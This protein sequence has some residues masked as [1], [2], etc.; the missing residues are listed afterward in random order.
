MVHTDTLNVGL[1]LYN[2]MCV[3]GGTLGLIHNSVRGNRD[4]HRVR[5]LLVLGKGGGGGLICR[6]WCT[7]VC[8]SQ[9][10]VVKPTSLLCP[11]HVSPFPGSNSLFILQY[12]WIFR[13]PTGLKPKA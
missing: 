6:Q 12:R 8:F 11:T 10:C 3:G 2:T 1:H 7:S 4:F 5:L 13:V 9:G